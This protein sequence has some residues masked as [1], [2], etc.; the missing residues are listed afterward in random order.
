MGILVAGVSKQFGSFRAVDDLSRY[1]G[2]SLQQ[3]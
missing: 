2:S 3:V 1:L